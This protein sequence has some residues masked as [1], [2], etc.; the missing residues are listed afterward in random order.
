M[1]KVSVRVE[2]ETR[3]K[4]IEELI[5]ELRTFGDQSLKVEISFD[6]GQTTKPVSLVIKKD[7][8]CVLLCVEAMREK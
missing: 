4:T 3:G 7:G 1:I 6:D 8:K 5:G 2:W